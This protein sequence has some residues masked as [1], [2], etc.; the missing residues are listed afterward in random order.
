MKTFSTA[1]MMGLCG[2]VAV[3]ISFALGWP[4]WVMFIAWVSYYLFGRSLKGSLN[5]LLQIGLGIGLGALIQILGQALTGFVGA[6]GFPLAV[7]ILIGSL[8]YLSR[9]SLL[10]NIPAW[11]LGLII[12]FGV[13]PALELITIARLFIPIIAGFAFAMIND[14]GVRVVSKHDSH[15]VTQ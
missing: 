8:A 4:T 6:V 2:A 3:A 11:F 15:P 14:L 5:A 7:F 9:I 13:H 12:F 1:L 10:S